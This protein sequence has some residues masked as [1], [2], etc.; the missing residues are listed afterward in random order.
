METISESNSN[1]LN[2]Q[3]CIIQ[4]K[5]VYCYSL[6]STKANPLPIDAHI[7]ATNLNVF[8]R[9]VNKLFVSLK[10]YVAQKYIFKICFSGIKPEDAKTICHNLQNLHIDCDMNNVT[11][12]DPEAGN[13][14]I[15]ESLS[16]SMFQKDSK[17]IWSSFISNVQ[18]LHKISE[19]DLDEDKNGSVYFHVFF[20]DIQTTMD[21]LDSDKLGIFGNFSILNETIRSNVEKN[22]VKTCLEQCCLFDPSIL[23][24]DKVKSILD[25]PIY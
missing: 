25:N 7:R 1:E 16:Q 17:A 18:N 14:I 15:V 8:K 3:I 10:T 19:I 13:M 22:K 24:V 11:F 4:N 2:I 20:K 23:C 12:L 5:Q 9:K 21:F 6:H